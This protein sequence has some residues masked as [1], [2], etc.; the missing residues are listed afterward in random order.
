MGDLKDKTGTGNRLFDYDVHRE[1]LREIG[2]ASHTV[3][4]IA[5]GA[6]LLSPLLPY[7][8]SRFLPIVASAALSTLAGKLYQIHQRHELI[9]SDYVK[10]ADQ[11]RQNGIHKLYE[12]DVEQAV[13]QWIHNL[14]NQE[15]TLE[16]GW[17]NALMNDNVNNSANDSANDVA[18]ADSS[19]VPSV[20]LF[21]WNCLEDATN[22][23]HLWII[24]GTG[25]GKS[26][27]AEW[28]CERLGGEVIVVDP[29]YQPGNYDKADL[30]VSKGMNLGETAI[31]PGKAKRGQTECNL[32]SQP[33]DDTS[34][35]EFL[36]WL[37][38]EM[39]RRYALFAQGKKDWPQTNVILDEVPAY[40]TIDGVSYLFKEL[41]T[42]A[43]KVGIRCIFLTQGK[44][45]KL[46]GLEGIS[47]LREN[48]TKVYLRD[49]AVLEAQAN[50]NQCK[51]GSR[52]EQYWLEVTDWLKR[53]DRPALVNDKPAI[54]PDLSKKR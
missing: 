32:I 36:V 24:A 54:V 13:N 43:R 28:V 6:L 44:Q 45:V 29:H 18:N 17:Q 14:S 52:A 35:C 15:V 22:F 46:I 47:D 10:I 48:L 8:V 34:V 27:F 40:A 23:P 3:N 31:L 49:F 16:N 33:K 50:L 4:A 42:Q 26:T 39:K 41:I 30:I 37:W 5:L 11:V 21:D 19:D 51:T 38:H 2:I 1:I 25:M 9:L 20:G 12:H 7:R 53:Q